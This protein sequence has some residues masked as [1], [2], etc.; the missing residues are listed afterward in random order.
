MIDFP[1]LSAMVWLPILGGVALLVMDT[2]GNT[3]CRQ[4]A[5]VVSIVT[6]ATEYPAVHAF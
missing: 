3:A 4:T 5:L 2:L 1:I 6:F